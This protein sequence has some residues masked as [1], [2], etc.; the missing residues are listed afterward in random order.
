MRLVQGAEPVIHHDTPQIAE[1][2]AKIGQFPEDSA[3]RFRP[4]TPTLDI[5]LE[6]AECS[7]GSPA[8]TVR[9]YGE[10][11]L[12]WR[13]AAGF[14]SVD[15]YASCWRTH[16]A[17]MPWATL[18]IGAVTPAIAQAWRRELLTR[19][20]TSTRGPGGPLRLSTMR[21]VLNI[22]RACFESAREDELIGSNPFAS[23][24]MPKAR[25]AS[26]SESWTVLRREEQLALLCKLWTLHAVD[27]QADE[28]VVRYGGRRRREL[29]PTK[30]GKV[31]RVPLFGM[32]KHALAQWLL[33]LP[34]YA[35]RNPHGLIFPTRHGCYRPRAAP[36]GWKDWIRRAGITR[37][38]RWHDLRH[39][40]GSSLVAGWWGR[41][42]SLEEV[43]Q[44]L[45][46]SS[47]QMTER[48][49]HFADDFLRSAA[50]EAE[51]SHVVGPGLSRAV[52]PVLAYLRTSA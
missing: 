49:A 35:E 29:V 1:P 9:A 17:P 44:M 13:R 16:V 4:S 32:A 7:L 41:R 15:G 39:T 42:W 40:C 20:S 33:E 43:R 2:F 51:A 25:G 45:G 47:V 12:E 30:A 27:V 52:D 24:R 37:R 50:K 11:W 8:L 46:H 6:R 14:R 34:C 28:V 22:T 5:E 10:R 38:F 48:Y 21:N 23:I 26:S 19:S 18:P 3:G 36:P 31:R